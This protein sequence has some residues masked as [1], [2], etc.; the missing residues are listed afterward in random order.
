MQAIID[1]FATLGSVIVS[2]VEFVIKFFKDLIYVIGLL[3]NLLIS[4]PAMIGWLPSA[5]ISLVVTTFS[6][7][8]IYK[9]MGREG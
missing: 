3:G 1:F 4:L 5:C 9:I 8:V 2:V 7:V 6:I